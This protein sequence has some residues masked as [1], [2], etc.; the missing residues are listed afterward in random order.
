MD[1]NYQNNSSAR[2]RRQKKSEENLPRAEKETWRK[3]GK[4][5]PA[6]P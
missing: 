1:S 6:R 5:T 2:E 4:R 3:S